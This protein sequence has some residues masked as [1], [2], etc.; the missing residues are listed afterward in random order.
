M[1]SRQRR[2]GWAKCGHGLFPPHGHCGQRIHWLSMAVSS[3]RGCRWPGPTA[4]PSHSRLRP[5]ACCHRAWTPLRSPKC[6]SR[7]RDWTSECERA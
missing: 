6:Q 5:E 1:V 4:G 7:M 2:L 3:P